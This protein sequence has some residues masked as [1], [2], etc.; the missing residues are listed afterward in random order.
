MRAIEQRHVDVLP[1]PA[2]ITLPERPRESR[3]VEYSPQLMSAIDDAHF[4]RRAIG[5]A[6]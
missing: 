2:A 6:R 4:L 1:Q 5:F 3:I